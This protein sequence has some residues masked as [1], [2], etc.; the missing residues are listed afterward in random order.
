MQEEHSWRQSS[1]DQ[2]LL[3]LWQGEDLYKQILQP[4][5]F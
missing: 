4:R 5:L 3:D 1:I 2:V